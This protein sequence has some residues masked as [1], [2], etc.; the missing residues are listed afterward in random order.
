M[1]Y[2]PILSRSVPGWDNTDLALVSSGDGLFDVRAAQGHSSTNAEP[3]P[4]QQ[5]HVH[6]D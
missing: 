3:M 2:W 6:V 1:C 4:E 5:K